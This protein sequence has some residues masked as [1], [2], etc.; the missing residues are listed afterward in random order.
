MKFK[1]LVDH[2][3]NIKESRKYGAFEQRKTMGAGAT[4]TFNR[5]AYYLKKRESNGTGK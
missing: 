3:P 4:E 2:K 1:K 5:P